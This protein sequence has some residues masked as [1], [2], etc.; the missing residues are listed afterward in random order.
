MQ[1]HCKNV[2]KGTDDAEMSKMAIMRPLNPYTELQSL[3][4]CARLT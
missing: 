4:H 3:E 1:M 2:I